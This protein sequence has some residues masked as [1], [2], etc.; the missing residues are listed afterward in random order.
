MDLED[1]GFSAPFHCHPACRELRHQLS[2]FKY[3]RH[4]SSV[5]DLE[6]LRCCTLDLHH[7]SL[8][9]YSSPLEVYGAQSAHHL[10]KL[11][12][13]GDDL[14]M[15]VQPLKCPTTVLIIACPFCDNQALYE[16]GLNQCLGRSSI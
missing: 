4:S 14:T 2:T 5:A 13:L 10:R 12:Q 11:G 15:N 1:C 3:V 6:K 16:E 8:A 9:M 7:L